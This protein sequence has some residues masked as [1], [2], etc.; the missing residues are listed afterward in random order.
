MFMNSGYDMVFLLV[1]LTD[2]DTNAL[3]WRRRHTRRTLNAAQ[4]RLD[5]LPIDGLHPSLDVSLGEDAINIDH[6]RG[7]QDSHT[8]R[9]V[10]KSVW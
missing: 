4:H 8:S 1:E 9:L 5:K 10:P 3:A 7:Q 6:R 2:G